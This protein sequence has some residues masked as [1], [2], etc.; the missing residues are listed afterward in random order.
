MAHE[1]FHGSDVSMIWFS[2]WKRQWDDQEMILKW[3]HRDDVVRI[4]I[5]PKYPQTV[6]EHFDNVCKQRMHFYQ[7]IL[8]IAGP[9]STFNI[10]VADGLHSEYRRRRWEGEKW[11]QRKKER[12]LLLSNTMSFVRC[13]L[14]FVN[15]HRS[16]DDK[17]FAFA[18]RSIPI[19]ITITSFRCCSKSIVPN[20]C[21]NHRRPIG[22]RPRKH[23]RKT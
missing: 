9:L 14:G 21:P 4:I 22:I 1:Y 6:D 18:I 2:E 10:M 19:T 3:F 17:L 12:A 8:L 16:Y 15:Q 23:T 7:F 5:G 11:Q 13:N 20:V